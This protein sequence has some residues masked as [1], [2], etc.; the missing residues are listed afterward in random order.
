MKALQRKTLYANKQKTFH[1]YVNLSVNLFSVKVLNPVMDY[2]LMFSDCFST[3]WTIFMIFHSIEKVIDGRENSIS[4][5]V[6]GF[7][8]SGGSFDLYFLELLA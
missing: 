8:D 5:S 1:M 6:A 3:F 7:E 4:I 2:V